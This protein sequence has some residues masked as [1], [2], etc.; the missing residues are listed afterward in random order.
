MSISV[1]VLQGLPLLSSLPQVTV[2]HLAQYA[3]ERVY[4]KR[5]IVL[6]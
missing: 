6:Q 5:E 2:S 4:A 1:T 3:V